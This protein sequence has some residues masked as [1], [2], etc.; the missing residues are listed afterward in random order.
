MT[1]AGFVLAIN[2][3]IAAL[4]AAIFA[5]IAAYDPAYRSARWFTGV[6]LLGLITVSTEFLLPFQVEMRALYPS[7]LRAFWRRNWPDRS[8]SR[9]AMRPIRR[10]RCCSRC[11]WYR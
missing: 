11:S 2:F 6:Y 5:W 10:G 8:V 9:G 4:F 3:G 1:G 7:A